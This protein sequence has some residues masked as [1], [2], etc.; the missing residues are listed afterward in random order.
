MGM[1]AM[2]LA[3]IVVVGLALLAIGARGVKSGG[4]SPHGKITSELAKHGLK[5]GNVQ[6]GSWYAGRNNQTRTGC[7]IKMRGR[8]IERKI[9]YSY[10]NVQYVAL[11]ID[12]HHETAGSIPGAE[13]QQTIA[14]DINMVEGALA[15]SRDRQKVDKASLSVQ[16]A[17]G[18]NA[19]IVMADPSPQRLEL[20]THLYYFLA[21]Q[22]A[23]NNGKS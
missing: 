5:V 21:A 12:N 20:F 2:V 11:D 10:D 17:D 18:N 15:I 14:D 22:A 8:D 9:I 23:S 6:F 19:R 3:G 1:E 7:L 16:F 13:Q 4:G